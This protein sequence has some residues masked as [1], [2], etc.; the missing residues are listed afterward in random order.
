VK[1][2]LSLAA[3]LA[4]ALPLAADS[5]TP[6]R[7]PGKVSIAQNLDSQL[8][9]DSMFRDEHGQ[10]VRLGKYFDGK[11]PVLLNFMYFDCPMLCSMVQEGTTNVLSQLPFTVGEEFDVVTISIDP[12]DKPSRAMEM[13]E[14]YL[15]RYGKMSAASGWHFLTGHETAITSV[16]KAVGFDYSYDLASN[17]FAH[18][19]A[20]IILTPQGRVSRYF[21]GT[22]FPARDVRL[23][24]V[25]A[26][27]NKIGTAADQIL[28]LCYHYDPATGK[29][30]RNAMMFVR[31]GGV[32]TMLG[33][34]GFIFAMARRDRRKDRSES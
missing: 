19:A 8:P 2:L 22:E 7:L 3:V 18:G 20:I 10:I 29:Y 30:S 34:G 14:K 15:K 1:R 33:L 23:G 31:A 24:L 25:E 28:L 11:R 16:T 5:S 27:A 21:F 26:S 32:A 13:K 9:L 4:L 17:Q 6:P 12:R